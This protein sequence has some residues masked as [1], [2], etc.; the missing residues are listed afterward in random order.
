M[1]GVTRIKSSIIKKQWNISLTHS[2]LLFISRNVPKCRKASSFIFISEW[3]Y[4]F[5]RKLGSIRLGT[6]SK[7]YQRFLNVSSCLYSS[8]DT[9]KA[10]GIFIHFPLYLTQVVGNFIYYH[11]CLH[12]CPWLVN[13]FQFLWRV[14]WHCFCQS[15]LSCVLMLMFTTTAIGISSRIQIMVRLIPPSPF[16]PPPQTTLPH[17]TSTPHYLTPSN[18]THSHH[19]SLHHHHPNPPA[20]KLAPDFSPRPAASLTKWVSWISTKL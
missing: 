20:C 18:T 8:L 11:D 15:E 4:K 14:T 2:Y 12:S 17:S 6:I 9:V 1:H 16:P 3:V 5:P 7:K 13:V 10:C 19:P